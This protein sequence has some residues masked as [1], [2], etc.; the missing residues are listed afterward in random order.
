MNSVTC[1]EQQQD[2]RFKIF[3]HDTYISRHPTHS[4]C[5][6][7]EQ[8][9]IPDLH[10]VLPFSPLNQ[11]S[12]HH[13][14]ELASFCSASMGC[15]LTY[16]TSETTAHIHRSIDTLHPKCN[17]EFV[18]AS[19][20]EAERYGAAYEVLTARSNEARTPN[21]VRVSKPKVDRIHRVKRAE[22]DILWFY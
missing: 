12:R 19:R 21:L 18:Y 17:Q 11:T 6:L 5:L 9:A 14:T 10:L 16:P 22:D 8:T 7:P 1:D 13:L 3:E 2:C 15:I 20:R 4:H